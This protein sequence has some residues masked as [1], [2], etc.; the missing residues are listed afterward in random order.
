[1]GKNQPIM[2]QV[3][4]DNLVQCGSF[5]VDFLLKIFLS[6]VQGTYLN[7]CISVHVYA[8][9]CK[10]FMNKQVIEAVH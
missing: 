9:I 8:Y 3:P 7:M 10:Y 4:E 1:M 6:K 5:S 2:S